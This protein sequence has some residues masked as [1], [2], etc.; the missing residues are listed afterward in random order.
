[1]GQQQLLL[2]V[3]GIVIVGMA[4]LVGIN[5]YSENSVRTNWDSL[6]QDAVRMTKI[7]PIPLVVVRKEMLN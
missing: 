2:L 1:M 5:A 6:L 4:I 3:M 7:A